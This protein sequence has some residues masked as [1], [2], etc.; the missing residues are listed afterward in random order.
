MKFVDL[1]LARTLGGRT[2]CTSRYHVV[3]LTAQIAVTPTKAVAIP[4]AL[5][6]YIWALKGRATFRSGSLT[7]G[8]EFSTSILNQTTTYLVSFFDSDVMQ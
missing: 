5:S 1:A 6:A 3:T 2:L 4:K 7:M 8:S